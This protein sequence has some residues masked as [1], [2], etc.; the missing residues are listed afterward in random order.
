[1]PRVKGSPF[2]SEL[3]GLVFNR[4]TV[5]HRLKHS[6]WVCLCSCGKEVITSTFQLKSGRTKS[7]GCF[8]R[9][10]TTKH[11]KEGT[12][13]YNTW[14]QMLARCN[15]PKSTSYPN[16]GAK[17]I[18]V[19][20]R[21]TDF[22][23]FYADMGDIQEGKTIDRIDGTK[24]YEPSNCRW[25]THKEQSRNKTNSKLHSWEGRMITAAELAEIHGVQRKV[26]ENRLRIGMS[27]EEAVKNIKYN[28]WNT[29]RRFNVIAVC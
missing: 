9:D 20:E 7:C 17:G 21:W 13:I 18:K 23:N 10:R 27:V 15:N 8:S 11:G 5:K 2:R 6:M 12:R 26:V 25:A 24:G 1:M 3:D 4:L 14:A 28:R 16:Y 29:P 19:C 22:R